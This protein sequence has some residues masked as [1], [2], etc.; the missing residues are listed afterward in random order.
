[1]VQS[2]LP[3]YNYKINYQVS[4]VAVESLIRT[5]CLNNAVGDRYLDERRQEKC[6]RA[7]KAHRGWWQT[8]AAWATENG[9]DSCTQ[10][11]AAF[12]RKNLK[13]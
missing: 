1:M 7:L 13:R 5:Q 3:F 8:I 9:M 4:L 6:L 2:W 12:E 11:F 10:W